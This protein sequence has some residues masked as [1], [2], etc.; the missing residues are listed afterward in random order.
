MRVARNLHYKGAALVACAVALAAPS[1]AASA[2]DLDPTFGTG[3]LVTTDFD[4]RGDFALAA[5]VQSDG[6]LVLAGN[7]SP[8]GVFAV[9][10]ALARYNTDG[11]LDPTFGTDGRVLSDFGAQLDAAFDVTL[12]PDGKIVAVGISAFDFAVARYT[13]AGAPDPTFGDGGLVRT[14]LGSSEQ[15]S[16]A[17]VDPLGSIVVAG[18]SGDD[19]AIARYTPDG[20]LDPTFGTDGTVKTDF[21]SF[22]I[23]FDVAVAPSGKIVVAGRNGNDFALARY[24][25]DGTPDVT[26]GTDG[27]TTTDF[28]GSDQ[29]F[30]LALDSSG[31]TVLAGQGAGT[32][33][34]ARYN[35]DG[36]LDATFGS[37]GK[38]TTTFFD[39]ASAVAFGLVIQPD[40]KIA[41]GGGVGGGTIASSFAVARYVPNGSL[42]PSFGANG[43]VTTTFDSPRSSANDLVLQPDGKLVAIGGTA[44]DFALARYLGTTPTISVAID[45]KPESSDNV[46]PL[47]SEG[48]VPVAILT[49]DIFDAATVQPG[50]VC[51][52][53]SGAATERACT[54]RSARLV[55]VN[56]DG[57]PDLLLHFE[58]A[59]TG[60]DAGDTEACLTGTTS[61]GISIE[62]CDRISTR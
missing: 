6:K 5:A 21:G 29:A 57:R 56:G 46:V 8:A 22:D 32:F 33:G 27:E 55:D 45:V 20:V 59:T 41:V 15:A 13:P 10:F 17:A 30:A 36:S 19:F 23:A 3:G 26:F 47:Q 48:V 53:D 50:S 60:I 40:G 18:F 58:T 24:N 12:Q 4:G 14:D 62:G 44:V 25:P 38:V 2:G 1:A 35:E 54:S 52:G 51:F 7:S 39:E 11:T 31:R 37:G 43:K 49:T 16:A 61:A 28:G 34:V 9:D 42:D